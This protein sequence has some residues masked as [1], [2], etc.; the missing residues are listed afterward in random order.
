M[1]PNKPF[2]T[3]S[4]VRANCLISDT[5]CWLWQGP[6]DSK[7]YGQRKIRQKM[8]LVHRESFAI[9]HGPIPEG[10]HCCHRCDTPACVNPDH[11]F[12]GT[13]KD[14][15]KDSANKGRRSCCKLTASQVS[16]IRRLG[17][18][19]VKQT[20]IAKQF[21]VGQPAI[22]DILNGVTYGESQNKEVSHV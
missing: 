20:A 21:G 10:Q 11:I 4:E 3:L 7:G 18:E 19:G 5:G 12:L 1:R 8:S 17:L 14:N 16:E 13:S 22:S 9:K 15:A 2:Q 6:K